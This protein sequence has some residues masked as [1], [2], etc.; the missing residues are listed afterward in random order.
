MP[1]EVTRG[2]LP[3]ALEMATML[4]LHLRTQ[5]A[6]VAGKAR[7]GLRAG[8]VRT[9]DLLG[10]KVKEVDV[11]LR[12]TV[13]WEAGEASTEVGHPMLEEAAVV[14]APPRQAGRWAWPRRA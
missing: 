11:L 2:I 3:E 1:L 13:S 14:P 4:A 12:V 7:A 6:G 8:R 10:L 9:G 5:A